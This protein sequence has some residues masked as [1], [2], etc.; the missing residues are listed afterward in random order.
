MTGPLLTTETIRERFADAYGN[1]E[2][3]L[4]DFDRWFTSEISKAEARGYFNSVQDA[5]KARFRG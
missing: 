2:N 5:Y 3:G 1:Y 4:E